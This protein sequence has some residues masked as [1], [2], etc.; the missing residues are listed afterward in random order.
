[1]WN[2]CET[3]ISNSVIAFFVTASSSSSSW[4]FLS[5]MRLGS[6]FTTNLVPRAFPSKNGWGGPPNFW[7]KS[8]GDE[9]VSQHHYIKDILPMKIYPYLSYRREINETDVNYTCNLQK[10]WDSSDSLNG[11]S[12][13]LYFI[14][15]F[16]RSTI[17]VISGDFLTRWNSITVRKGREKGQFLGISYFWIEVLGLLPYEGTTFI[18]NLSS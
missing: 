2:I 8:P 5:Y 14:L 6:S 1:M 3:K 4:Y 9:V 10:V 13:S 18:P 15:I 7:G 17:P 11:N 12:C 16:I